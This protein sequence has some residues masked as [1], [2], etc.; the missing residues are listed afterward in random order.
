ML[1]LIRKMM[2]NQWMEW[3]TQLSDKPTE[4]NNISSV[5]ISFWEP[6]P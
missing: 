4:K 3:G 6:E 5:D 1:F 2:I